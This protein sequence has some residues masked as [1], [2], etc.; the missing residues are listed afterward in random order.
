M[1]GTY[2]N[3]VFQLSIMYGMM[4]HSVVW[5]ILLHVYH[6]AINNFTSKCTLCT[7]NKHNSIRC[8]WYWIIADIK[9]PYNIHIDRYSTDVL[10]KTLTWQDI[11][12]ALHSTCPLILSVFNIILSIPATS[13][14]YERGFSTMRQVKTDWRSK[15]HIIT[16]NDCMRISLEGPS[17]ANFNPTNAIHN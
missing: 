12:T 7:L 8:I 15:L 9:S 14:D 1:S 13:V 6:S 10:H 16:L 17:I 5:H 3:D 4:T 2:N 11:N